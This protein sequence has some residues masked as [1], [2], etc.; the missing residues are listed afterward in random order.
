MQPI[1]CPGLTEEVELRAGTHKSDG[2]L[3]GLEAT[4]ASGVNSWCMTGQTPFKLWLLDKSKTVPIYL[5]MDVGD[6]S[7]VHS[8][9]AQP[10]MYWRRREGKR[11]DGN[12]HHPAWPCYPHPLT[13]TPGELFSQHS[14]AWMHFIVPFSLSWQKESTSTHTKSHQALLCGWPISEWGHFGVP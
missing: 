10:P 1:L 5:K 8:G 6:Y 3:G 11:R 13:K 4:P 2:D 12:V 14:P 9:A 7:A